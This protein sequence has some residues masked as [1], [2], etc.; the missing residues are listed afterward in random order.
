MERKVG[1]IFEYGDTKY[2]V[3]AGNNGCIK[4]CSFCGWIGDCNSPEDTTG[5]CQNFFRS[6]NQDVVFR[7]ILESNGYIGIV[8]FRNEIEIL[9]Y[10][11]LDEITHEEIVKKPIYVPVLN[12][13]ID[14]TRWDRISE[15]VADDLN[16]SIQNK[17]I[18]EFIER[19]KLVINEE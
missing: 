12:S 18:K 13:I 19:R 16:L 7:E 14:I 6:D 2:L 10:G 3:L 8:L 17:Y 5:D 9:G 11:N 1:E 15:F 4:G